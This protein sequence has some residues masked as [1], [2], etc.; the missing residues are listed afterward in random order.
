MSRYDSIVAKYDAKIK[1]LQQQMQEEIDELQRNC[2]HKE[3]Y[4]QRTNIID[5]ISLYEIRCKRCFK[6]MDT[7][8]RNTRIAPYHEQKYELELKQ[9][10]ENG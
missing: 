1:Q 7:D 6:V 3:T 10:L 4:R 8:S 9:Q 5:G 2:S